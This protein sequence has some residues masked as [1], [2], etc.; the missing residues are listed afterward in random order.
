M[1]MLVPV[2]Y[3]SMFACGLISLSVE[4]MWLGSSHPLAIM[5]LGGS[6]HAQLQLLVG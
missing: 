1:Y 6:I 2:D 5:H 3:R 4:L